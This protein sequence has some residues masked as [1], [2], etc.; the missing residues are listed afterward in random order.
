[1]SRR[2]HVVIPAAGIGSRMTAD[3]PKQYLK[4][5]GKT[6]L[7]YSVDTL[8]RTPGIT[9]ITVALHPDDNFAADLQILTDPRVSRVAGGDERADS[10]LAAL[11]AVA[12]EQGD[13]VLV[14]DA[15]R[16]GLRIADVQRLIAAV[17]AKGEGGILAEPVVDTVKLGDAV[18]RVEKTLDRS[19]LWRAQTPQ[20]FQ[21][22][23]LI[24]ALE[25][26]SQ[27]GLAVTDE[28]SAMELAGQPVQLVSGSPA[29]LKVTV[30]E[31][32]ELAAWYLSRQGES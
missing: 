24:S 9:S 10:V 20:M 18:G 13:W 3:T 29:N 11:Y 16:P 4:I 8:L 27:R 2:L 7:E 28:A 15:A 12:G 17:I 14:H 23:E 21:L 19:A 1:M 25:A 32:L 31:D 6:L 5:A 30:P 26:A 22:G